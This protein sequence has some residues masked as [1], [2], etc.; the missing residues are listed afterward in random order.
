VQAE[1]EA[2]LALQAEDDVVEGIT[3]R[4]DGLAPRLAALDTDRERVTRSLQ[5]M[6]TALEADERKKRELEQRLSDHRQRHEKNLA[7]LDMVKRMREATAA[8]AQVEMG[9]KILLD[10]ENELRALSMRVTEA[11]RAIEAQEQRTL[12]LEG[13]QAAERERIGGERASLDAELGTARA[14]RDT[15]AARVPNTLRAKYER[16][17]GRRRSQS[18]FVLANGACSACDTSIPVQRRQV[19]ANGGSIDVCEACGVLLY[20]TE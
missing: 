14:A 15:M 18:V 5:Q 11:R 8:M 19:M 9:R 2:L 20:A 10:G 17:R 6:Q 12:D 4:L 1:I 13:E 7:Q 3:E 16:I